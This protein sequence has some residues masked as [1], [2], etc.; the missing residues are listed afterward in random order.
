MEVGEKLVENKERYAFHDFTLRAYKANIQNLLDRGYEFSFFDTFNRNSKFVLWRHDIDF[1]PQRALELARLEKE[2]GVRSTYFI[3]PHSR[4]YHFLE[5]DI[6][7]IFM[8]IKSMGHQLGL[9]FD[10]SFYDEVDENN[11]E[12]LLATEKLIIDSYFKTNIQVFSFHNPT[13]FTLNWKKWE[14]AGM[15]NTYAEWIQSNVSY[16]SDSNGIWRHQS[17]NDLLASNPEKI[18]F[19]THPVWWT[20]EITSPKERVISVIEG[21]AKENLKRQLDVWKS[22]DREFIDW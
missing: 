7:H 1:A 6:H 12:E 2:C 9:H 5:R 22:W 8:E 18:Q 16:G 3:Q 20:K 10:I 21:R 4:F 19:L 11:I 17:F 15:I 14:C 13:K